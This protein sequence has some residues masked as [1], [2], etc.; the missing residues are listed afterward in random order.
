MDLATPEARNPADLQ[1]VTS[2]RARAMPLEADD[3][4]LY[5]L[6]GTQKTPI[7]LN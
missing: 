7:P 1:L 4:F 6:P 3:V 2:L 5:P